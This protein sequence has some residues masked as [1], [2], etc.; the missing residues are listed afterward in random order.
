ME[1][2]NFAYDSEQ[3]NLADLS[4]LSNVPSPDECFLTW[5]DQ[6]STVSIGNLAAINDSD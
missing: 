3:F 1:Y 6:S 4:V 5:A 2:L